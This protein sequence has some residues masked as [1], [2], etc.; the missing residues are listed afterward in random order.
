MAFCNNYN[1]AWTEE[2]SDSRFLVSDCLFLK[3]DR[4]FKWPVGGRIN[5]DLPQ[6]CLKLGKTKMYL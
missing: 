3:N 2:S 4:N 1:R 5:A 6:S